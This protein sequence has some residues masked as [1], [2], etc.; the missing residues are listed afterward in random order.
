MHKRQLLV[1]YLAQKRLDDLRLERGRS[2]AAVAGIN[3]EQTSRADRHAATKACLYLRNWRH[4]VPM[5]EHLGIMVAAGHPASIA[6]GV[7]TAIAI[8]A[9][10]AEAGQE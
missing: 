9:E 7:F 6:S 8:D 2:A 1:T 3:K 4:D 10:R 5:D